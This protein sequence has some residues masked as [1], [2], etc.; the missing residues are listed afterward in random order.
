MSVKDNCMLKYVY[1]KEYQEYLQRLAGNKYDFISDIDHYEIRG[2]VDVLEMKSGKDGI[3][4]LISWLPFEELGVKYN[5]N[6][7]SYWEFLGY[8]DCKRINPISP[9]NCKNLR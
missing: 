1:K 5:I 7:V 6:V 2:A 4:R 9:R 8:K 3:L